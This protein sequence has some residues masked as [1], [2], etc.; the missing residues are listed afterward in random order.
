MKRVLLALFLASSA[1]AH[2][3]WIEPSTFRPA[4]GERISVALRL[5]QHLQSEPVPRIPPLIQRFILK[6]EKSEM[7]VVGRPGSD[8]AGYALVPDASLY[9]IGYESN[10]F[11]VTLDAQKFEHYLRDEG[12]ERIIELRAKRNQSAA[13]G[14]ERFYRC[15]KALLGDK[16]QSGFETPLGFTLELI[17]RKNP[18]A[19]RPGGEL[20]LS[21]LFRG[22]PIANVLVVAMNKNEPDKVVRARTDAKG[23]VTLPI[24]RS[25]FWLV[26]AVHMEAAP[27]NAG[28]DWESWW[29]SLTFDLAQ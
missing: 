25:G 3:F 1:Y 15:A 29:A 6:G 14:N 27:P 9:W 22:K 28:A 26:K 17:P 5:G 20:P 11:P 18:Y 24:G 16:S 10:A 8:P 12:L 23:R 19:V 13:E 2:D 21:L 4:A 7:N